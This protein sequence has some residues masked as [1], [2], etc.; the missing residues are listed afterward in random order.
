[1]KLP[2]ATELRRIHA[3]I[4]VP[5]ELRAPDLA[6]TAHHEAGHVVL[7]EWA[8][9]T[10]IK[11]SATERA[12]LAEGTSR[13]SASKTRPAMT[14]RWPLHMPPPSCTPASLQN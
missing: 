3:L 5:P 7:M 8:G 9:L 1:M 11:A 10:P 13:T 2:P 6:R 12:G 4:E 14:G